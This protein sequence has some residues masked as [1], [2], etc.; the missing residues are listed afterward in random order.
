MKPKHHRLTIHL[1]NPGEIAKVGDVTWIPP[2]ME[3]REPVQNLKWSTEKHCWMVERADK[4]V[5]KPERIY[6]NGPFI[7]EEVEDDDSSLDNK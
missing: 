3:I 2:H 1:N 5:P 6:F 7:Y 4:D